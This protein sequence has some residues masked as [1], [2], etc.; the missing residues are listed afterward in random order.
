VAPPVVEEKED[1]K[2]EEVEPPM[3]KMQQDF[4]DTNLLLFPCRN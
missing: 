3:Q 2:V 4:H 1:N